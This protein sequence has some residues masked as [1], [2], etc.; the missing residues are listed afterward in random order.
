MALLLRVSAATSRFS[1]LPREAHWL[2]QGF[3]VGFLPPL[4]CSYAL[5]PCLFVFYLSSGWLL[6]C[7][8]LRSS[9]CNLLLHVTLRK[10]WVVT[11]YLL[12]NPLRL[13]WMP[14]T[15][16]RVVLSSAA[17]A[18]GGMP[19]QGCS[20]HCGLAATCCLLLLIF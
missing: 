6:L 12:R 8:S 10:N 16:A 14:H 2:R 4:L 11:D 13:A 19:K 7:R 5:R 1:A 3:T 17:A 15:D 20:G 9:L 18:L